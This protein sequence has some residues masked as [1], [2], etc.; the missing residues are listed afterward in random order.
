MCFPICCTLPIKDKPEGDTSLAFVNLASFYRPVV[1]DLLS[2]HGITDKKTAERLYPPIY[3]RLKKIDKIRLNL[4]A[5]SSKTK[6]N[7]FKQKLDEPFTVLPKKFAYSSFPES[8]S[9]SSSSSSSNQATLPAISVLE[10]TTYCECDRDLY[11]FLESPDMI[12]YMS[13]Q[14]LFQ[15]EIPDQL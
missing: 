9:S 4:K 10:T 6:H 13:Q 2:L 12:Y 8:S 1:L 15:S 11:P 14:H 5:S 7:D 3:R